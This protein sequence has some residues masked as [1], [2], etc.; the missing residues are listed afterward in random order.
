M[1]PQQG[2]TYL[3]LRLMDFLLPPLVVPSTGKR[4]ALILSSAQSFSD[5]CL[6]LR[7]Q[8]RCRPAILGVLLD[9]QA[10]GLSGGLKFLVVV[11]AVVA[12]V[13]DAMNQIVEMRHLMQERGC[14]LEDGPVKVLGAKIDFPILLAAGVPYLVDTAPAIRS[15]PSVRR[16]SDGRAG[17]T[18]PRKNA[19]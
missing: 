17:S 10:V 5:P 6:R 18:R 9:M 13:L 2:Q 7:G 4:L 12:Y 16:Y 1:V 8:R 11:I 15:T 3:V 14:Q 19:R